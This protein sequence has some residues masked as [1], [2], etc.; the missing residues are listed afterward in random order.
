MDVS[1]EHHKLLF[2]IRRSVRYHD[3]RRGF[4]EQFH[5]IVLFFGLLLGSATI[6]LFAGES[7]SDWPLSVK[8]L[9]AVIVTILSAVDLVV[10]SSQKAWLHADLCRK[11]T[12]LEIRLQSKDALD[13]EAL[14]TEITQERLR[15]EATEPPNLRVL[16]TLCHNE[17]LRAMGY[18]SDQQVRVNFMQRWLAHFFDFR[19]HTLDIK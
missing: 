17:L 6:G 10:R 5:Q 14:I 11:F 8:L 9:P 13:S 4:Y 18:V 15:I 19:E 1:Q 12:E 2:G 3:R 7:G 16:D